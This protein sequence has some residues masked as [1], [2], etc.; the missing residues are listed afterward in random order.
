MQNTRF[1]EL[2]A[3]CTAIMAWQYKKA[4]SLS[5]KMSQIPI[6]ICAEALKD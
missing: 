6:T 1:F 5:Y 2:A 3:F 4:V